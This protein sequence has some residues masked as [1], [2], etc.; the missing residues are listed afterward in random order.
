[1][2][3]DVEQLGRKNVGMRDY[4]HSVSLA[5]GLVESIVRTLASRMHEESPYVMF[6]TDY[7]S[8]AAGKPGE[9]EFHG[10]SVKITR[11]QMD[12]LLRGCSSAWIKE[13]IMEGLR[14]NLEKHGK[15]P[16]FRVRL[17]RADPLVERNRLA[18]EELKRQHE[19]SPSLT[20]DQKVAREVLSRIIDD[21]PNARP[22]VKKERAGDV[23]KMGDR[24]SAA[25][26]GKRGHRFNE[27][28]DTQS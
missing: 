23:A 4:F 21:A 28:G 7:S 12:L 22:W 20:Q 9:R 15:I 27:P 16:E 10:V 2:D 17:M 24:Q 14:Y 5:P 8:D 11:G 6:G 13:K 19:E 25:F 26:W 18:A 3:Y 1:M